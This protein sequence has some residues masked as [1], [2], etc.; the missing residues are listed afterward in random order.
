MNPPS[1]IPSAMPSDSPNPMF[2]T[3]AILF[4]MLMMA[5]PTLI[6]TPA[7]PLHAQSMSVAGI[8]LQQLRQELA[9]RDI[10]ENELR[11]R[12]IQRGIVLENIP[13]TELP[14][15][16]ATIMDVV[17]ELQVEKQ[18]QQASRQA[19]MAEA[20]AAA[21]ASDAIKPDAPTD[22]AELAPI[23]T[24]APDIYGHE[25]FRRGNL[26]DFLLTDGAEAP[27][28]YILGPG[29]RLRVTIFG[30]SQGDFLLE[31][32][33]EGYVQPDQMAKI[34]LN[35]ITYG[36]ARRLLSQR[37]GSAYTFRSDQ[38][39]VSLQDTR[40]QTIHIL[41]EAMRKG[42]F[43]ISPLNTVFNA[44]YIAGGPT[45]IGSVRAIE[46]HG[47]GAKRVFDLYEMLRDPSGLGQFS[48]SHQDLLFIPTAEKVVRI[49]GAVQRPMRYELT[50]EES[51]QDLITL[52]GGLRADAYPEF[53]QIER[54]ETGE[55]ALIDLPLSE[56]S[57]TELKNGD[58]VRIRPSRKALEAKVTIAGAVYYPQTLGYSP[59]LT[60]GEALSRSGG[61]LPRAADR[62]FLERRDPAD[63]TQVSYLSIRLSDPEAL[64]LPTQPY[65]RLSV[66]D[67]T[68]Y[69]N[70][71]EVG[72]TGA[73]KQQVSL[74]F[75]DELTLRDLFLAAGG[76]RLG[77]AFNRVQVFRRVLHPDR[78]M[79]LEELLVSVDSTYHVLEPATFRLRPF[80]LVVVRQTPG[81]SLETTVE[82]NGEVNYPGTYLLESRTTHLSELIAKAGGLRSQADPIGSTLF[83][84]FGNRGF[85]VTNLEQALKNSGEDPYDPILFPGD[86]IHIRQRENTVSLT[87]EG[88]NLR[89]A[90]DGDLAAGQVTVTYQG[91]KSAKWYVQ[92]YGGGFVQDADLN[93]VT[94]Q[95]KNGQVLGTRRWVFGRRYP[96]VRPGS[97]IRAD[98]KP[99]E[100]LL[101]E[102]QDKVD[103][104]SVFNRTAQSTT[105]LL[106]I[107]VILRQI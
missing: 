55:L 20:E 67:Q 77:V 37:F 79:E 80:D 81:Y 8:T 25:L 53:A 61:P 66:Y 85:V 34:F 57:T 17:T 51:L 9:K 2:R 64:R 11:S 69:T 86:V 1:A 107:L 91:S 48:L 95:L 82:I 26:S 78:P 101:E 71:G 49:Q 105:T 52:A 96:T 83:R 29:D 21:S 73:V 13:P 72:I 40:T 38:F 59:G 88:L 54:F 58:V 106:T 35:G 12:L 65:D 6:M 10:S 63:T 30:V 89:L 23:G 87:G 5:F 15:Y 45:D 33:S 75:H 60:L 44:L 27:E 92:R 84:T 50:P 93:T 97:T 16:R 36:E 7:T 22:P 94:V 24:P 68:L 70:T 76:V 47:A 41:G 28:S 90:A 14:N 31:V 3:P 56:A 62:A 39:A 42:S 19:A 98:L 74:S 100:V 43:T 32:N 46:V 99:A 102:E 18:T 103:W 4:C 104:D